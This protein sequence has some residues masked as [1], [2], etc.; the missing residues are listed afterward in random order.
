MFHIMVFKVTLVIKV[1]MLHGS[2]KHMRNGK[3]RMCFFMQL[4]TVFLKF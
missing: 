4:N 2:S 3:C 1:V